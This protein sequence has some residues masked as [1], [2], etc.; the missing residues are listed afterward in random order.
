MHFEDD[1]KVIVLKRFVHETEA[2][3]AAAAL[4]NVGIKTFVS[5]SIMSTMVPMAEGGFIL[6]IKEDD[7][8]AAIEIL[9]LQENQDP[10]EESFHDAT[11]GDIEYE[12]SKY[13]SN[14]RILN[15]NWK[16]L[17]WIFMILIVIAIALYF[18]DKFFP[19]IESY[20]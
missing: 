20:N 15:S 16:Y 17:L 10:L 1:V 4:E 19:I 8:A 9:T 5:N 2:H 6:H 11:L 18:S 7:R 14:Q 3:I 12:K 13:L